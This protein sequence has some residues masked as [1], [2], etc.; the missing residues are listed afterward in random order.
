M[1]QVDVV[2]IFEIKISEVI[3]LKAKVVEVKW[4]ASL[5]MRNSD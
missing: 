1:Y 2:R 3:K 4:N 5:A